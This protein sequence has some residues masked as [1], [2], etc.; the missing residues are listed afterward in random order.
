MERFQIL[1]L[2]LIFSVTY[3]ISSA[4]SIHLLVTGN[5][6]SRKTYFVGVAIMAVAVL[7]M[8][9]TYIMDSD[10]YGYWH[11]FY[12]RDIFKDNHFE[13]IYYFIRNISFGSYAVF[14]LLIWGTG[15]AI[16]IRI[17]KLSSVNTL[18]ALCAFIVFYIGF[19]SYARV[20]LAVMT[21]ALA[22]NICSIRNKHLKHYLLITILSVLSCF[23][24]K[25]AIFLVAILAISYFIN[26]NKRSI[27]VLLL[28][29]PLLS[30]V[31]NNFSIQFFGNLLTG[32]E[33]LFENFD[34]I[35]N[36]EDE[37]LARHQINA[38][39]TLKN[40][41]PTL[42][43]FLSTLIIYLREKNKYVCSMTHD[44]IFTR[45][46]LNASFLLIYASFL[47]FTT[48]FGQ[49]LFLRYILMSYPFLIIFSTSCIDGYKKFKWVFVSI[50]CLQA[51]LYYERIFMYSIHFNLLVEIS[52]TYL[53]R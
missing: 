1:L 31:V 44:S 34:N 14:R 52:Q 27:T 22:Y 36:A 8:S 24:H 25:S 30:W 15:I 41:A 19:F 43:L 29:F 11:W 46:N 17:C 12:G 13:P 6:R 9:M 38:V 42:L 5:Y 2:F 39:Y 48:E 4:V 51:L 7:I 10:Y 45:K 40:A 35:V 47:W 49:E 26:I 21:A 16:F 32:S 23:L 50:F 53:S 33:V 28:L 20:S 18:L 3:C 37:R